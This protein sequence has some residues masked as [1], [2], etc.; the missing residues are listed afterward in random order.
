M[1]SSSKVQA[2]HDVFI[3][4]SCDST[5]NSFVSH[6]FAAFKRVNIT[7]IEEDDKN[8]SPESRQYLP[9]KTRLAIE[10]SKICVVVLSDNF[11]SSKHSLTTLV[12]VIEWRHGKAGAAVVPVFY[13]VD[14]TV[15]EQQT[16]K[17]GEAFAEHEISEP[18]DRVTEWKNALM[19]AAHIK[20]GLMSNKESR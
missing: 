8:P 1:S 5:R 18:E 2:I 14:R 17:Y 10:R 6:L 15:V 3:G 13:G 7:V 12:E 19:E 9:K 11:A 4:S 16:G 20:E